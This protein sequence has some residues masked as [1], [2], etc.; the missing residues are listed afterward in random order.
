MNFHIIPFDE[1]A[2]R[3]WS[4]KAELP[5]E[6]TERIMELRSEAEDA[7]T[8]SGKIEKLVRK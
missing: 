8:L 3:E 2:A 1:S 6:D 4:E 7:Q 5:W